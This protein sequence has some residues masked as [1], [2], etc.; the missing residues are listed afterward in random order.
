M[1]LLNVQPPQNHK[2]TKLLLLLLPNPC[3]QIKIITN[4][5]NIYAWFLFFF[6]RF[7]F[8]GHKL[9]VLFRRALHSRGW[10]GGVKSCTGNEIKNTS[11]TRTKGGTISYRFSTETMQKRKRTRARGNYSPR[12]REVLFFC[13]LFIKKDIAHARSASGSR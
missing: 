6:Q 4:R 2:Q 13:V 11:E 10:C 5:P 8:A 7:M 3:A 9:F 1:F 12:L